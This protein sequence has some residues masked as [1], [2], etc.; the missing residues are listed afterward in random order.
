M[1]ILRK[2]IELL[3]GNVAV[4]QKEI[5]DEIDKLREQRAQEFMARLDHVQELR[6]SLSNLRRE[7]DELAE[8][9]RTLELHI[10]R[11]GLDFPE[12][13]KDATEPPEATPPA[14]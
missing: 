5:L 10:M 3:G 2:L 6:K 14:P 8:A 11:H 12:E 1:R 9:R 7:V 4:H 13:L